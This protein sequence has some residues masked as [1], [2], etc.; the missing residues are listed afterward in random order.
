MI[1]G[2]M[3]DLEAYFTGKLV[4]DMGLKSSLGDM[5][6]RRGPPSGGSA[7]PPDPT[8]RALTAARTVRR[9]EEALRTLTDAQRAVLSAWYQPPPGLRAMDDRQVEAVARVLVGEE[10]IAELVRASRPPRG[11]ADATDR[12][13]LTGP[14]RLYLA[15]VADADGGMADARL[16]SMPDDERTMWGAALDWLKGRGLVTRLLGAHVVTASGL[17]ALGPEAQKAATE[18]GREAKAEL[19]RLARWAR[20]EVSKARDAYAEAATSRREQRKIERRER[21]RRAAAD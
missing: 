7:S 14:E 16:A 19:R 6:E 11:R 17:D 21:L 2:D 1:N 13:A 4:G 5:L 3:H 15:P 18:R 9:V 10:R 20:V 12:P 8:T